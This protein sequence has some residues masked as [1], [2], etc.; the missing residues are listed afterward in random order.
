MSQNL[1]KMEE[2]FVACKRC[3]GIM[4]EASLCKGE[5]TCLACSDTPKQPNPVKDVQDSIATLDVKCPLLRDCDWKGELSEAESHL[6]DCLSF[7]IVCKECKQIF[8][9][10]DEEEH[11]DNYCPVRFIDCVHCYK[12]GKAEDREQHSRFCHEYPISCPNEC[13]AEFA[14]KELSLHRSNCE[15]E[16]VTCPYTEYGCNAVSMLRRDLLAHKKE[17]ILDHTDMSFS[18]MRV[19]I[20]KLKSKNMRLKQ[21]RTDMKW[22]GLSMKQLD[23]VE[24]DIRN[25]DKLEDGDEIE[26]PS[27]YVNDYKL[28]IYISFRGFFTNSYFYLQRVEGEFDRNLELAYI[29]HY[30]AIKVNTQDYHRSQ[31]Q[32]GVMNYQLEIGTTSEKI[33]WSRCFYMQDQNLAIFYFDLNREPLNS[34]EFHSSDRNPPTISSAESHQP[35]DPWDDPDEY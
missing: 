22:N 31:Y 15:L 19:E 4:R 10:R 5:T 23:G 1:S 20:E 32:E 34:L 8:P 9:R 14:R 7:L 12:H 18:R 35:C 3:S 16:V 11:E 33:E 28:R 25:V 21:E 2:R 26:G 6:K 27:F 29:T 24:W 30:R 13:E 17:S